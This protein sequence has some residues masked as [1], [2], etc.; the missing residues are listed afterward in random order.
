[1]DREQ[2]WA[3]SCEV[4]LLLYLPGTTCLQRIFPGLKGRAISSNF[5]VGFPHEDKGTYL[6]AEVEQRSRPMS[7]GMDEAFVVYGRRGGG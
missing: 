1:M 6:R 7:F 4:E 3:E 2:E 5:L